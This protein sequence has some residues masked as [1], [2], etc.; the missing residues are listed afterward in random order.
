MFE[1]PTPEHGMNSAPRFVVALAVPILVAPTS[2][3]AQVEWI[4][5]DVSC[6]TCSVSAQPLARLGAPAGPGAIA[7]DLLSVARMG[8]GNVLLLPAMNGAAVVFTPGGTF[9]GTLGKEGRGPG[10]YLR[11][12]AALA[13]EDGR[14]L[15]FD[16]LQARVTVLD[17]R[18]QVISTLPLRSHVVD[19]LELPDERILVNGMVPSRE[20]FGFPFHVLSLR[21]GAILESFG[22]ED[23][24][25]IVDP[26]VIRRIIIGRTDRGIWVARRTEYLLE[27]FGPD[28]EPVR[29]V[30]REA[31][32]FPPESKV[33][34]GRPDTP[35]YP[36]LKAGHL[37]RSGLIWVAVWV[38]HESW[39]T[40]WEGIAVP[41]SGELR[42]HPPFDELFTTRLEV[43]DQAGQ[44]I[45]SQPWD[46]LIVD[47]L[48]DDTVATTHQDASGVI[49]VDL[50]RLR[51]VGHP[52]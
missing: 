2:T 51:L 25:A 31:P 22:E 10:E 9:V 46:H 43:F 33:D 18:R 28:W 8:D 50:W 13:L 32:W 12:S 17:S 49:Y 40:A 42:N 44:L 1:W 15:I 5:S 4:T 16:A 20:K 37:S 39:E 30:R 14:T 41:P 23:S 36:F 6:S 47:W 3:L 52:E 38:P 27:L 21:N 11:P 29:T 19:A 48:D 7:A 34:L 35:P 45:H 24:R 26:N